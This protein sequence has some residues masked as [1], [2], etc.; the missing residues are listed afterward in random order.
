[1]MKVY[2]E[3]IEDDG[4]QFRTK[5]LLQFGDSWDLI[6]SIVMKNPGGAKPGEI[7]TKENSEKLNQF[8]NKE[9][10]QK[11]WSFTNADNTMNNISA[12]FN[13]NYIGYNRELNGI[14]QIFN[15]SNIC[16]TNVDNAHKNG[17]LTKSKFLLPNINETIEQFKDRPVYL[18]FGDFYTNKKSNHFNVL[19]NSAQKL[20]EFV[21]NSKNDYLE[22]DYLIDELYY[23]KNSFYHPQYLKIAKPH[24]LENYL[25]TLEKFF[26]LY[27]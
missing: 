14:I 3:F 2:A 21:K 5:A 13:G 8:Y 12:I 22:D 7:I 1:M 27:E 26:K 23:H 20:F 17:N 24:I 9:I 16:D 15:L 18:G 6:G 25:P 11:N 19:K 10:E 4:F